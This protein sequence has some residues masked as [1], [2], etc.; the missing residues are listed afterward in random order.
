MCNQGKAGE[1]AWGRG[2]GEKKI[3]REGQRMYNGE[4]RKRILFRR[5]RD[6]GGFEEGYSDRGMDGGAGVG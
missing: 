2:S 4:G 1:A 5:G 6:K 3:E